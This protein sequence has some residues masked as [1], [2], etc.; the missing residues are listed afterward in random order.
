[1][2]NSNKVYNILIIGATGVGKSTLLNKLLNQDIAKIGYVK[3][4]TSQLDSYSLTSKITLWDSP[5]LGDG[6]KDENFEKKLRKILSIPNFIDRI[7]IV[8]GIKNKGITT[9]I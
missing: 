5:G 3:P 8:V 6:I 7:L 2:V 4:E 9:I 1:M